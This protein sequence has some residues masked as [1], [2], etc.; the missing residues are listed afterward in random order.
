MST[1][2]PTGATGGAFVCTSGSY[3][4]GRSTVTTAAPTSEVSYSFN[5]TRRSLWFRV[6][7]AA[8]DQDIVNDTE[9]KPGDHLFS[10]TPGVSPYYIEFQL[11]DVGN[12]VLSG[13]ARV[14]PGLFTLPTPFT[15]GALRS[16]RSEQSLSVQWLADGRVQPRVFERLGANSWSMRLFQP[17]DGPFENND[18]SNTSLT[19]SAREGTATITASAPVFKSTDVGSLILLTQPGQYET[20]NGTVL[21]AVTDTIRVSGT[22]AA[23]RTFYYEVSG[24][25]VA[26]VTLQR[27]VGSEVDWIDVTTVTGATNTSLSDGLDGQIVYYRLKVTAYTSGTAVMALTYAGGITDGG[28]PDLLGRCRQPDYRRCARVVCYHVCNVNLG[29]WVMVC[30]SGLADVPGAVRW[31]AEL[32]AWRAAL[33]VHGGRFRELRDWRAGR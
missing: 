10:F 6:G 11:R 9:F 25:F 27:S 29:I 4:V 23:A 18:A 17:K 33:A 2:T 32:P 21:N 30:A 1:F 24:T 15:E 7:S 3:A 19:P 31:P 14:A 28:R 22:G 16:L 26:S 12:A 8:G 13:L 5:V 20:A